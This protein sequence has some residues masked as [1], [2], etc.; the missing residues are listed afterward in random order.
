MPEHIALEQVESRLKELVA[1]LREGRK[2]TKSLGHR[3]QNERRSEYFWRRR[4]DAPK[5]AAELEN[6]LHRMGVHDVNVS[7]HAVAKASLRWGEIQASMAGGQKALLSTALRR[8]D[9]RGQQGVRER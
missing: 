7:S 5:Y 2:D 9:E 1:R 6:E 3:L 4:S 8:R